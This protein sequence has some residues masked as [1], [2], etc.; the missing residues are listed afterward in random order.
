M[1]PYGELILKGKPQFVDPSKKELGLIP[2]QRLD[3]L[4]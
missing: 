1:G 3:L 2:T 4:G